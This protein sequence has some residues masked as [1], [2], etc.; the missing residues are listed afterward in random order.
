MKNRVREKSV[1]AGCV[2]LAALV[3]AL[4]ARGD[5]WIFVPNEADATQGVISNDVWTLNAYV[6]GDGVLYVGARGAT[7]RG[8]AFTGR[9]AGNLDLSGAVVSLGADGARTPWRIEGFTQAA[10]ASTIEK[11]QVVTQFVFPT[12]TKNAGEHLF[13][14]HDATKTVPCSTVLTNVVCVV[15]ELTELGRWAFQRNAGLASF[16][17]VAPAMTT[18]NYESL[19][20]DSLR[21]VDYTT[22]QLPRVTTVDTMAIAW[23]KGTGTLRL[24]RAK[25]LKAR[26]LHLLYNVQ[27]VELGTDYGLDDNVA[28]RLEGD[29]LDGCSN[30]GRLTFGPYASFD[31]ALVYD[32]TTPMDPRVCAFAGDTGL[33]NV[34]FTG[35]LLSNA[36]EALDAVLVSRTAAITETAKAKQIVISASANLGWR[37]VAKPWTDAE[38]VLRP[39]GVTAEN[40]MGVYE[41][42]GG[43]RKAWLVHQFSR[44]DY[45]TI[46]VATSDA[47]FN[48]TVEVECAEMLDG[49]CL[50]GS[51]VTVRAVASDETTFQGWEG[52]PEGAVTNGLAV[53]F[54]AVNSTHR[55]TLKTA[56]RWTYLPNEGVISNR[57][58]KLNVGEVSGNELRVGAE[59][60][61]PSTA[62]NAFT[63]LG[64]GILDLSGEVATPDGARWWI[65]AL[66]NHALAIS[67][68]SAV[69]TNKITKFVFPRETTSIGSGVLRSYSS[70]YDGQQHTNLLSRIEEIIMDVPN[71]TRT[72]PGQE[73]MRLFNL[74]RLVIRAPQMTGFGNQSANTGAGLDRTDYGEWDV[75]GV[76]SLDDMAIAWTSNAKG[77]LRLSSVTNIGSTALRSNQFR[78]LDLGSRL[79]PKDHQFLTMAKESFVGCWGVTS[80]VFGAYTK[81]VRKGT[82]DSD[83]E[84]QN[85][86][87]LRFLGRPPENLN[88]FVDSMLSRRGVPSDAANYAVIRA[89]RN[90][91]WDKVAVAVSADEAAAAE[92]LAATLAPG[93]DL[94]GVYVNAAGQRVAWLV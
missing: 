23:T 38:W 21:Q 57:V 64:E 13:R 37:A 26:A 19:N 5:E 43:V 27:A 71:Y 68:D 88:E 52:L 77:Y 34:V 9:G 84:F 85:L 92:A 69:R 35:R 61:G 40:C 70:Q 29:V 42:Q 93:E 25:T 24:P 45:A 90:L 22:W 87:Q 91:G 41:T 86:K 66:G 67:G 73:F 83:I 80:I 89:S 2:G 79:Q 33:T 74:K 62:G 14:G 49:R 7:D 54:R 56:P 28:L 53:T 81:L 31:L 36:A 15:P 76:R 78:E 51:M 72:L 8:N 60:G 32:N 3:L 11:P 12:T 18:L 4:T 46:D 63:D 6:N 75:S 82:A 1:W 58:W 94:M 17:L 30:M 44:N 50:L 65:T 39:D 47:R 55:L 48:D 10:F 20:C 59:Q 16:T